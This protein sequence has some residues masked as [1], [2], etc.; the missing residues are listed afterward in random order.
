MCAVI[1]L[2]E[3]RG[4][5]PRRPSESV[6]DDDDQ[7]FSIRFA[8]VFIFLPPP[9]AQARLSASIRSRGVTSW[10]AKAQ[11][12]EPCPS[13]AR[14]ASPS[15]ALVLPTE[16]HSLWITMVRSTVSLSADQFRQMMLTL[17]CIQQE[18]ARK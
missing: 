16:A 18:S 10:F 17:V 14:R 11:V 9:I 2:G 1:E 8:H 12:Q 13:A 3:R 15:S 7:S 4:G 6:G 5:R